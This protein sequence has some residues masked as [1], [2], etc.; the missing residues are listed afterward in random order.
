MS[1]NMVQ[2]L[3]AA[4]LAFALLLAGCTSA[5]TPTVLPTVVLDSSGSSTGSAPTGGGLSSGSVI[6]S[7]TVA[8]AAQAAITAGA[9]GGLVEA[10][11]VAAG[12]TVEAGQVLVRLAGSERLAAA[13]S[14]AEFEL[15]SAQQ[16]LEDLKSGAGLARAQAQLR[17]AQAVDALKKAQDRRTSKVFRVGSDDQID[18]ARA[19]LLLAEDNLAKVEQAYGGYANNPADNVN[20]AEAITAIAAAREA[21][22]K[23]EA[24]LNYLLSLPNENELGLADAQLALAQAE[25]EAAQQALDRLKDGP[26]PA[27]LALAEARVNNA[28][29][30]VTAAKAALAELEIKAPLGGL[31]TEV[32][33]HSGEWAVPG[34]PLIRLVDL[35][36]LR[37]ETSDLSE[38]DVAKIQVGQTVTVSIEALNQQATGKVLAIAPLAT[39]LGGDVVYKTTI[40]LEQYPPE[41]RAGMSVEVSFK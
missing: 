29:V 6:A 38:M 16:A 28:Q 8:P 4:M 3:G 41:L 9:V 40:V 12:D 18:V 17:L 34:Q 2:R 1:T 32:N 36:Q 10:V 20:K 37:V 11:D 19:A 21:R 33:I 31:A 39:S 22:N 14:A 7:G 23:A 24:N 30:Q 26:D 5:A 27:Q 35:A 25:L 13:V 15:L